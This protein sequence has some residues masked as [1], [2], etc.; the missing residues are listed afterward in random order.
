MQGTPQVIRQLGQF[1][2]RLGQSLDRVGQG[3]QER[4]A[5]VEKRT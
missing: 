2:R 1:A 4:H 3:F 5:Y